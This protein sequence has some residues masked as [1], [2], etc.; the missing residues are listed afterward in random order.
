M[1]RLIAAVGAKPTDFSALLELPTGAAIDELCAG[2]IDATVL[3]LG[4]P[5]PSTAH[6]LRD[7]GATLVPLDEP[8]VTAA[9]D[10]S[11]DFVR[12]VIPPSAYASLNRDIPTFAVTA[13]LV[14]LAGTDP[15]EVSALVSE[16]LQHLPEL[17]ITAPIL[18]GLA[19]ARMQTRGLTAPLHDAAKARYS[20]PPTAPDARRRRGLRPFATG[21]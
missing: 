10:R 12:A 18:G 15:A 14:T 6:A 9:L 5:N 16:T 19:P 1:T 8:A 11:P 4:H 21:S 13:T 20:A 3:I 2:R 7:C 17:A